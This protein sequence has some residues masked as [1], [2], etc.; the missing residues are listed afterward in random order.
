MVWLRRLLALSLILGLW[1]GLVW[2]QLVPERYL[3]SVGRVLNALVQMIRSGEAGTAEQLTLSRALGGLAMTILLALGL[4][5][6]GEILPAVRRALS[7]LAEILRPIPPAAIVPVVSFALGFGYQAHLV[8]IVL[9]ALW[10]L[11]YNAIS[12]LSG[13]NPL[14]IQTG[15]SFGYSR[16]EIL[17]R[18][19]L[20][21]ALPQIFIGLRLSAGVSLI[22]VVVAEMLGGRDGTGAL[23]FTKA[24]GLQVADVF[25]LTLICGLNGM[26]LNQLVKSAR[27]IC[28][29]WHDQ[30]QIAMGEGQ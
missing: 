8:T 23:L 20:P 11:Y 2:L 1:Q 22:A 28:V 12:A 30:A 14:L 16:F 15:R 10:P 19:I 7:P 25:A 26:L 3:P 4:A 13:V 17:L 21:Q 9:T 27:R 18:I 5:L 6:V 24:F 29:G